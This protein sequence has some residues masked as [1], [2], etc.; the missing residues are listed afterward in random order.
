MSQVAEYEGARVA[1]RRRRRGG[2][3][4]LIVLLALLVLLIVADRVGEAVAERTLASKARTELA[5]QGVTVSGNPSVSISGFPFLTQVASGRYGKIVIAVDNPT[6]QG[7]RL[8][9]LTVTATGVD[10]P[11]SVIMSHQGQIEADRVTGVGII[12]WT[13]FKQMVDLTRIQNM[14]IDP[15]SL[16]ISGNDNGE[17]II[18]APLQI[19]GQTVHATA[20]GRL[21]VSNNVVHVDISNVTSD[22]TGLAGIAFQLAALQRNLAFDTRIPPLPFDMGL[23]SVQASSAGVRVVAHANHVVLGH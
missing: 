2:R 20:T 6:A 12:N 18:K 7:I 23:D 19:A 9:S 15:N 3:I 16:D 5:S 21:S 17:L 22:A 8:D 11:A 14:D 13:S 1:T 10:A 4:L